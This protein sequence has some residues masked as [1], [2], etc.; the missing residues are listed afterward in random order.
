[1]SKR[2]IPD[3]SKDA[4]RSLKAKLVSETYQKILLALAIIKEGTMEDIAAQMR[5]EPDVVWKRL[6]ELHDAGKIYRPGNKRPLKSGCLGYTWMLVTKG[7]APKK[8]V[9]KAMTGKSVSDFAKE[10]SQIAVQMNLL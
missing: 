2:K 4:Y 6:S 9:E 7:V 10:I 3:T 1:M 8:V 5:V